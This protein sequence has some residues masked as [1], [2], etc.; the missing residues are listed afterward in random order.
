M[1]NAPY[2]L[3]PKD[4]FYHKYYNRY[5]RGRIIKYLTNI[6]PTTILDNVKANARKDGKMAT[7]NKSNLDIKQ[8]VSIAMLTMSSVVGIGVLIG[9]GLRATAAAAVI[10]AILCLYALGK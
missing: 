3:D 5:D 10:S 4:P 1:R 8:R 6:A 2:L 7:Q 9:D